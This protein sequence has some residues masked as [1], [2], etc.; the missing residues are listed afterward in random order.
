MLRVPGWLCALASFGV[1]WTVL[2]GTTQAQAQPTEPAPPPPAQAPPAVLPDRQARFDE[3]QRHMTAG[4]LLYEDPNH[5]R[6][7]RCRE[8]LTEFSKA[9]ELTGLWKPLRAVAI[10]EELLELSGFA[11]DHY[12]EVLQ[13]GKDELTEAERTQIEDSLRAL[14][15]TTTFVRI[16]SDQP[17]LEI[18]SSR[19][20]EDGKVVK[21]RYAV[22]A[23]GITLGIP[24][25]SYTFTA[26]SAG[27]PDVVWKTEI[28]AASTGEHYFEFV[29]PAAGKET[30]P[31][32]EV[33]TERPVPVSVWVMTG[34]TGACALTSGVFIGLSTAAGDDV[35]EIQETEPVDRK[36]LADAEQDATNKTIVADVFLGLTA[37]SFAVT[38]I[39][40]F[41][42]PEVPV[43]SPSAATDLAWSLTPIASDNAV[44][45]VFASSF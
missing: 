4:S 38:L 31:A 44:G 2:E 32:P 3:A 37:A 41:T 13:T 6:G 16:S 40:Y 1:G 14:R 36:K 8:A 11:I 30:G 25:G 26:S 33:E 22:A 39:L 15:A 5:P 19:W 20:L 27:Y 24:G 29:D 45:A 18:T 7:T 12:V 34:V 21:N 28:P 23:D 17:N 42:R 9:Y 10:C 35:D 43:Q